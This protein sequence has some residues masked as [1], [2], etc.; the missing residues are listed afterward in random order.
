MYST[1]SLRERIP[2]RS[3]LRDIPSQLNL[4][5]FD[6]KMHAIM[7][8]VYGFALTEHVLINRNRMLA[9][10]TCSSLHKMVYTNAPMKWY[11]V[12]SIR[13]NVSSLYLSIV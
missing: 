13:K 6:F 2:C 9:I 10:L 5:G 7:L 11:L 12:S 1:V 3:E 8:I 4:R